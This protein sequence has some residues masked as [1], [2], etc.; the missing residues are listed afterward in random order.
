[1][2]S[3]QWPAALPA[4]Q[5]RI[6]RPTDQLDAV[7][8]FY[9]DGLGLLE[10]DRFAGHAGYR[11]VLLGLP[12]V[13]HHLEFTEHE[14]GSPGPAPSRDNLLVFSFGEPARVHDVAAR[15][16]R[17]GHGAVT[18][19]NPYWLEHGA[20]TVE[21]PDGWRVVLMAERLVG[22][23]GPVDVELYRGERDDLR[24]LFEL[25]ED[26]PS[27]LESY[28]DTGRVLI[29]RLRGEAVGHLQLLGGSGTDQAEV[30][31]MAVYE[32]LQGRGLGG[33]L[34]RAAFA[35]LTAEGVRGVRVATAAADVDNLRF[36]QRHG[37]RMYAVERDAFG[38][39]SGYPEDADIAGIP[40]RD[41]VWLERPLGAPD[42]P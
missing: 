28:L 7:V 3:L 9:R 22:S 30:K 36:Y 11:G 42:S 6:A 19:E 13:D 26:S 15:L 12:G 35:L 39:A 23:P 41:R 1:M 29:L 10:L 27:S 20:I 21:D 25:A 16:A 34:L 33:R 8:A 17:G 37:F 38:P 4:Q 18:P 5:V 24:P 31:N 14:D 32:G 40:L 2:T